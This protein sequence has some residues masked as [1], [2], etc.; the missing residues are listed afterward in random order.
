[1]DVDQFVAVKWE[2]KAA[3]LLLSCIPNLTYGHDQKNKLPP[4]GSR[5][6]WEQNRR[7]ECGEWEEAALGFFALIADSPATR[8]LIHLF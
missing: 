4:K 2:G 5:I 1:M 8:I 7:S 6:V 3:D